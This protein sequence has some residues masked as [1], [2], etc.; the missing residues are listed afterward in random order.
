MTTLHP[1]I[2]H[3]PRPDRI[4]RL[5]LDHRGYPVPW[6][7][8][9][10]DGQPDHRIVDHAKFRPA[11]KEHRCWVC[12]DVL[13][14]YLTFAIGP[15][16]TITRTVSEPPSHKA[17]LAYAVQACPFLARPH[18]HRREAGLPAGWVEAAGLPIDRNPGVVALW[19]TRSYQPFHAPGGVLFRVG[20]PTDV[21]W[22]AEGRQA[23]RPEVQASIDS[24]LPV[25][26]E[27]AAQDGAT[28]VAA[29]MAHLTQAMAYLPPEQEHAHA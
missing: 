25:L 26:Q 3:I 28:A 24:G 11:V 1:S 2:A 6:F 14:R 5:P 9:L 20:E 27:T 29:L 8:A 18:A 7:V 13:G 21:V 12:G 16:C 17:C 15:M 22:Y 4:A 10:V 23:T 19:T